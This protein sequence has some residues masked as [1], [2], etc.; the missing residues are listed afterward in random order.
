MATD[1]KSKA[2]AQLCDREK[3]RA[4]TAELQNKRTIRLD[5]DLPCRSGERIYY[6]EA[7]AAFSL[8]GPKPF[9]IG[10]TV[11]APVGRH[12]SRP[13]ATRPTRFAGWLGTPAR[14]LL[15]TARSAAPGGSG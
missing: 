8:A 5:L 3:R 6:M 15:P 7:R 2:N 12:R 4:Y 14:T 1:Y 11:G 13:T 10:N 9:G